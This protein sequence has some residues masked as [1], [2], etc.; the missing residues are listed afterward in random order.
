MAT[1]ATDLDTKDLRVES[2]NRIKAWLFSRELKVWT[3]THGVGKL[4]NQIVTKL[5]IYGSVVVKAVNKK[6]Y[7]VD[8]KNLIN[9]QSV[10]NLENS[11]V[12]E[13]HEYTPDE[14]L[15]QPW[16]KQAIKEVIALHA[17]AKDPYI[18]VYESYVWVPESDIYEKG[19][20]DTFVR[21]LCIAA[22]LHLEINENKNR[23]EFRFVKLYS[24]DNPTFPYRE[25]HWDRISGRWLGRG[26]VEK[27]FD[28]QER[29]NEIVNRLAKVEHW[30]SKQVFQTRDVIVQKNLLTDAFDGDIIKVQ[31][32]ITK[33]GVEDRNAPNMREDLK[34]WLQQ[35]DKLAFSYEIATGENL[36]SGT[37]YRL[38]FIQQQAVSSYFDL[39]REEIGLFLRELIIDLIIPEFKKDKK[40]V[41]R[42]IV[43]GSEEEMVMLRNV[44]ADAL[45][46]EQVWR[47]IG[48][49]NTVEELEAVVQQTKQQIGTKVSLEIP[50]AY[51]EN[52]QETVDINITNEQ[53]D[54]NAKIT[55]LTTAM[56]TLGANPGI[57]QNPI[58][59]RIF[60]RA[61]DAAG[62]NSS[63][64]LAGAELIPPQ[65]QQ[66]AGSVAKQQ[67]SELVNS[68]QSA[69]V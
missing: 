27:L 7:L 4:L 51:Y 6:A 32:E 62:E 65:Q 17:Q 33:I 54:S 66:V 13:K 12:I 49:I 26:I 31:S 19:D 28:V 20:P 64:L 59:R 21:Y 10:E 45:L 44:L 9:D 14:L 61:L 47:L 58:L 52:L 48:R 50:D 23:K 56:Q 68:I 42:M 25:V 29:V 40:K 38:G 8:L 3:R 46:R 2:E 15:R 22:G 41:H 57:L 16:D 1:K 24:K 67:P 11:D 30:A 35:A 53:V 55:T 60:G 18:T 43:G 37:P 34:Y 39:K 63:E 69:T 36:P 5:P